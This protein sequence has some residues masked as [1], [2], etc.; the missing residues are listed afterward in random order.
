M[1][2]L[3][4]RRLSPS[5]VVYFRSMLDQPVL[6]VRNLLHVDVFGR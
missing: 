3:A 1:D 2:R 6:I 4:M 5:E